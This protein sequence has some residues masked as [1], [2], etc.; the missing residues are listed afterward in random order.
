MFN[1]RSIDAFISSLVLSGELHIDEATAWAA[2]AQY[3]EEL[4]LLRSNV[5]YSE[6]RMSQRR[7][8]SAPRLLTGS[9][10]VITKDEWQIRNEART[11]VGSI[12][13]LPLKGMMRNSGGASS[14][15]V[16]DLIDNLN[17]AVQNRNIQ[18]VVIDTETGG[19]ESTAG[20][21][22]M[23]AVADAVK[24]KPVLNWFGTCASAG[25]MATLPC[26]ENIAKN[27][28]SQI[29][30]IGTYLSIDKSF[31]EWYKANV[32]DLYADDSTNKNL[33]FRQLIDGNT[34]GYK[35]MV[36][37]TN[38]NFMSDVSR[39]R[40]LTGDATK[41][42]DTLSGKMFNA[43]EGKKRGLV[44]A[45]GNLDYVIKRVNFYANSSKK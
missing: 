10:S 24:I 25:V 33:A 13:M 3:Q 40:P 21:N 1:N 9:G 5:P 43:L 32:M 19:G 18:G 42:A 12:F 29:G 4:E 16:S 41:Q 28:R 35:T 22:L 36:N 37:A 11:P 14:Y 34:E 45:V 38:K 2:L 26:N 44:D 6:L 7:A 8:E 23:Y 15:G 31:V 30:S 39:F 17:L 27:E 20:S